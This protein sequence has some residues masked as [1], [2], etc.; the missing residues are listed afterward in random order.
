MVKNKL[1]RW[2][3]WVLYWVTIVAVFALLWL[4]ILLALNL[5]LLAFATLAIAA[6]LGNTLHKIHP[7]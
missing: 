6:I 1:P 5:N 2:A 4:S 3:R 7:T